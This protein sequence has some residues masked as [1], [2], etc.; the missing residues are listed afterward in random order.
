MARPRAHAELRANAARG[1]RSTSIRA[2]PPPSPVGRA[3]RF[4]TL[5][6]N[7]RGRGSATPLSASQ[8]GEALRLGIALGDRGAAR[9]A[10]AIADA[11][12][13]AVARRAPRRSLARGGRARRADARRLR[14]RRPERGAG[15][16]GGAPLRRAAAV[17]AEA[18]GRGAAAFDPGAPESRAGARGLRARERR[19]YPARRTRAFV[20]RRPG[21]ARADLR[22]DAV[23]RADPLPAGGGDR[24]AARA[25]RR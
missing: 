1:L 19:A 22:A 6:V 23:H 18:A 8:R 15:C 13:R 24:R 20:P 7:L 9:A 16:R 14:R 5:A 12:G 11:R 4:A 21:Q 2:P 10:G 25:A 3:P 17:P